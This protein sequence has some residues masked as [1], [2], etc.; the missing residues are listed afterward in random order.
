MGLPAI[1][2]KYP[3]PPGITLS[4]ADY[5]G[6]YK[7]Q[8]YDAALETLDKKELANP[9]DRRIKPERARILADRAALAGIIWRNVKRDVIDRPQEA[10]R[11]QSIDDQRQRVQ[12]KM[13]Q[14]I[15]SGPRRRPRL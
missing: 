8:G 1:H 5:M 13:N 15:P 6:Q 4:D 7:L 11:Q 3:L 10:A 2:A 9:M 14:P 12:D